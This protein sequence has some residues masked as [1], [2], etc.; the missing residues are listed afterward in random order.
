[1]QCLSS[2]LTQH[3]EW[4]KQVL[5]VKHIM[6]VSCR[7]HC[8]QMSHHSHSHPGAGGWRF[9]KAA[10]CSA[11]PPSARSWDPPELEEK[12]LLAFKLT[13]T[14]PQLSSFPAVT[15]LA[16][17]SP[18]SWSPMAGHY[19]VT[20]SCSPVLLGS[21]SKLLSKGNL[22][23]SPMG[24]DQAEP[25]CALEHFPLLVVRTCLGRGLLCA[26]EQQKLPY[27]PVWPSGPSGHCTYLGHMQ[28]QAG[29]GIYLNKT[30]WRAQL[31]KQSEAIVKGVTEYLSHNKKLKLQNHHNGRW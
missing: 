29:A 19:S 8:S 9:P 7:R 25:P 17:P 30:L 15:S 4:P 22:S 24:D 3:F 10:R 23:S 27:H 2:G 5:Q 12:H 14:A 20:V 11:A 28:L 13:G 18:G 6:S 16:L 21:L 31:L 1:M 26:W